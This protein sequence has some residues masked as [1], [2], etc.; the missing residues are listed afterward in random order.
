M[1]KEEFVTNDYIAVCWTL[2]CRIPK[3][4]GQA[5]WQYGDDGL[6]HGTCYDGS[7]YN[8]T[9]QTEIGKDAP[10]SN[11]Q[12]N[13]VSVGPNDLTKYEGPNIDGVTWISTYDN[14]TYRHKGFA[15]V[16]KTSNHS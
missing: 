12:V 8:G 16:D 9:A 13:G 4:S 11:V 3:S 1:G 5:G 2:Y 6:I 15:T 14:T 10:V 7:Y